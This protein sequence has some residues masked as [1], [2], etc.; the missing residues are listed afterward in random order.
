MGE[1]ASALF[2]L[3]V[4]RFQKGAGRIRRV[5]SNLKSMAVPLTLN[6]V[7]LSFVQ[8]AETILIPISLKDFGYSAAER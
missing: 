5:L 8:S 3:T 7:A 4:V 2:S 6:R 1:V